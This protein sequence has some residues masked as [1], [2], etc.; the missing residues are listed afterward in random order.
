MFLDSC[1]KLP[2]K[3]TGGSL[4]KREEQLDTFL[5]DFLDGSSVV[6]QADESALHEPVFM[7]ALLHFGKW[8]RGELFSTI[9]ADHLR[10]FPNMAADSLT[11]IRCMMAYNDEFSQKL[12]GSAEEMMNRMGK[13]KGLMDILK[14]KCDSLR[15]GDRSQLRDYSYDNEDSEEEY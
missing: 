14:D 9:W 8:Q 2:S 10:K 3:I 7:F 5:D 4:A 11:Y 13:V 15:I 6:F 12:K 1:R